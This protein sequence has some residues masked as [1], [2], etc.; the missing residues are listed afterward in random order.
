MYV[1]NIFEIETFNV[2]IFFI[3]LKFTGLWSEAAPNH[4]NWLSTNN[5]SCQ[6]IN[7]IFPRFFLT[8][9]EKTNHTKPMKLMFN[10]GLV[11]FIHSKKKY[12]F[13]WTVFVI[14]FILINYRKTKCSPKQQQEIRTKL[15][16]FRS[17]SEWSNHPLIVTV[18]NPNPKI[19]EKMNI[20]THLDFMNEHHITLN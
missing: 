2:I 3:R 11:P 8:N 1:E 4:N 20:F 13:W 15:S 7:F 6:C 18:V 12:S 10:T 14:F 9:F 5:V 16:K 17:K 19:N